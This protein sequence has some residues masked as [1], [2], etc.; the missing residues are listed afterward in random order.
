M[1]QYLI[2]FILI[3]FL[4]FCSFSSYARLKLEGTIT[5]TETHKP[6][7]GVNVYI[8]QMKIGT[9]TDSSGHYLLE[10][11][12]GEYVITFSSI[13]YQTKLKIFNLTNHSRL[14]IEL[15]QAAQQLDEIVISGKTSDYNVK[16]VEMSVSKLDLLNIQKVPVVLGEADIIKSLILQ[17]GVSTVGEGAGGFNVRGG[18]IDENLVILDDAPIY[19]TS[20]LLGFF[21]AFHSD[22]LQDVTLHK[23]GIPAQYGSRLSSVL[24]IHTKPGN[25]E[26]VKYNIGLSPMS[27]HFL[28]E[29][30]LSNNKLTFMTAA[31]V[32]FP[33][34]V[35]QAIPQPYNSYRAFFYDVNAKISYTTNN[36][37]HFT[38]SVYRSYDTFNF[39]SDSQYQW[40][41]DAMSYHWSHIINQKLSLNIVGV[42]SSY[43]LKV[44]DF[45]P[46]HENIF[47]SG[48]IHKE[49]KTQ[50]IYVPN[51]KHNIDAGI[52]TIFYTI[53]PGKRFPTFP[54]SS[55]NF[56]ELLQEHGREEAIYL[57]DEWNISSKVTL[58]AGIRYSLFQNVGA[59][60]VYKY[61]P[62]QP[63][64]VDTRIDSIFYEKGETVSFSHG[65]EPRI[66]LRFGLSEFNSIKMSYNRLRQY[67]SLISNS[68]A[69][70]P[71]DFWKLSDSYISPQIVD[72]Y[73]LG[74]FH[75]FQENIFE[76]SVE[77]FY[78][79]YSSL[80]EYK[81][82]AN[83]LMNEALESEL[84]SAKG[85]SYGLEVVIRKN[86]GKT[87]GQI[88]YSYSRSLS[89]TQSPSI[90]E[91]INKGKW[92]S[93]N[94]DKPHNLTLQLQIALGKG[95]TFGGNFIYQTGRPVTLPQGNYYFNGTT[96]TNFS[97]R[98]NA[99]LRNY[100]HADIAF[101]KDTRHSRDQ[102]KYHTWGISIYNIYARQN[103]YSIYFRQEQGINKTY[104]L[105]VFGTAI[106]SLTYNYYF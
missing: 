26:K 24:S 105:S 71:I 42:Y 55:I 16:N 66:S 81:N 89:I 73:T 88:G 29:G 72:Q 85:K 10:L 103:P 63:L 74:L 54:E 64:S 70:S 38:G 99:R 4:T 11:P 30:P 18:K 32:A 106:P 44:N 17:P 2:N 7:S 49:L 82:G 15:K 46:S 86:K 87:N 56:K 58:Q 27:S 50:F 68:L 57:S 91:Q 45:Q 97:S 35:I 43:K 39:S 90:E 79:K 1:K 60:K 5:D 62:G 65:L 94:F 6:L 77:L 69:V 59:K 31:R 100:H 104:E 93:T 98:N 34:A 61:K 12:F 47:S 78:K 14:D 51:E 19:N 52:S 76:T 41:T 37:N 40:N 8:K 25:Q 36:K 84:I 21:S 80:L 95:W 67:I 23:G 3:I 28:A 20:H 22:A 75:N 96:I 92:Y 101:H 13:G 102:K 83:L 48:I 53:S 9:I 33:N